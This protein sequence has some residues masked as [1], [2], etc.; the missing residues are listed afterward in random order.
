MAINFPNS[1]TNGEEYTSGSTTWV[2]DGTK[3]NLKSTTATTNDSMPIGS[4]MWF[5]GSSSPPGWIPA[6]GDAVSRTTYATLFATIGTTYGVGDGSTTFNVPSVASTTGAYYIRYTTSLGTVTTT[7]LATSPVGTM[8][9]WPT[10]S[11]Y[12]TG[13]LRADGSP[14]SRVSYADLFSLI[15][16]TYGTGDGSTTFNLPNLVAAGSGSPVK[17]IKATLGGIV[18]PSTV[19]HAASHAEGGSDVVSVTLNQVPNYQSSRNRIINGSFDVWQRGA[20]GGNTAGSFNADRWLIDFNG[21]G[22]TRA[23]TR[24]TFTLGSA[25]SGN[26]RYYLKYNQSVAGSSG[27]YNNIIQRVED[28]RT[29]AGETI[30]FSLW[31]KCASGTVTLPNPDFGQIYGTGGSPSSA[32]YGSFT[33]GSVV[34]TTS[35]ARFTFTA[36]IPSISGK[37]IGTNENSYLALFINLPLNTTFNIDFWGLQ[38]EAGS[39]AT[40]FEFEPFE[41]TLRKCQRYYWRV[42]ASSGASIGSGLSVSA[43]AAYAHITYPTMMRANPTSADFSSL[44]WSDNATYD[45]A[46]S[47]LGISLVGT[48]NLN[49][50]VTHNSG[51]TTY[52]PG[53]LKH[54]G[55]SAFFGLSAEL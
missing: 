44:V 30:T 51:A 40:P 41:T 31:A 26:P 39:V 7:S 11:S 23:I 42:T 9:D 45:L 47:A 5:A 35:W 38:L 18:E 49:L 15:G 54:N 55:G 12:P 14:V 8:L 19:S 13:Y 53:M 50:G 52:R 46:V 27:T 37:T 34:V 43:T 22:A 3:W 20:T 29:F 25:P 6:N 32:N 10:T 24:Q 4:I 17:I 2:Y 36:N 21:T 48:S 33:G 1:P 28:V 16:T